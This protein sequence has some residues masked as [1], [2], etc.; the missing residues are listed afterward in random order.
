[1]TSDLGIPDDIDAAALA[2]EWSRQRGTRCE[3]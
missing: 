3:R 1:V 2:V